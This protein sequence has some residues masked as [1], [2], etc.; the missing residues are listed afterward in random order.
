VFEHDESSFNRVPAKHKN[1]ASVEW[2][3]IS[4][5]IA[6]GVTAQIDGI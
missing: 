5:P 3:N 4:V 6:N 2:K 1:V